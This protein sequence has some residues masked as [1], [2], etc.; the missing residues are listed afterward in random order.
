MLMRLKKHDDKKRTWLTWL[1]N[2]QL[3]GCGIM[4]ISKTKQKKTGFS[5]LKTHLF[6]TAYNLKSSMTLILPGMILSQTPLLGRLESSLCHLIF[7]LGEPPS[8]QCCS[9]TCMCM[10]RQTHTHFGCISWNLP[11]HFFTNSSK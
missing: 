6:I 7:S 11:Y 8:P 5:S 1:I 10:Q 4:F 3:T 2:S 9:L